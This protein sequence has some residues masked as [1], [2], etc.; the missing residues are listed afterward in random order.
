MRLLF[1]LKSPLGAMCWGF[2]S[3]VLLPVACV[4]LLLGCGKQLDPV[5]DEVQSFPE[6]VVVV[7]TDLEHAEIGNLTRS[8]QIAKGDIHG[9]I[10]VFVNENPVARF[11]DFCSFAVTPFLREGMNSLRLQGNSPQQFKVGLTASKKVSAQKYSFEDVCIKEVAPGKCETVDVTIPFLV[12]RA[13]ENPVFDMRTPQDHDFVEA[14]LREWLEGVNQL[15][16]A[17]EYEELYE[18]VFQYRD[19]WYARNYG[20]SVERQ[21]ENWLKQTAEAEF[22]LSTVNIRDIRFVYGPNSILAYDQSVHKDD[23]NLQGVIM[24]DFGD[25]EQHS[26]VDY[27]RLTRVDGEWKVY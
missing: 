7:G 21:R 14:E 2:A 4:S 1:V 23:L 11:V 8:L 20:G 10:V 27:L 3:S 25:G 22:A 5:S 13:A 24:A 19:L 12:T 15:I 18:T 9:D 6:Y 17:K 16:R 26:I